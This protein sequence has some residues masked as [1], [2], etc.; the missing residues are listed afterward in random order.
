MRACEHHSEPRALTRPLSSAKQESNV[1]ALSSDRQLASALGPHP[2]QAGN[3]RVIFW[4]HNLSAF[5][6]SV[7]EQLLSRQQVVAAIQQLNT[8]GGQLEMLGESSVRFS[9]DSRVV[10]TFDLSQPQDFA[11]F[12]ELAAVSNLLPSLVSQRVVVPRSCDLISVGIHSVRVR[13]PSTA[14]SL[15][16]AHAHRAHD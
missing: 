6:T 1:I 11:L 10:A 8:A 3:A 7:G 15:D 9:L 2:Q 4:D 5:V 16:L 14:R 13:S 12:A